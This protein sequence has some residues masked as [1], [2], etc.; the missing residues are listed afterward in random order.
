VNQVGGN[1]GLVFDGSSILLDPSGAVVARAACFAEDLVVV[2]LADTKEA[3]PAP[4]DDVAEIWQAL[5]L[6][7]RDYIRKCG[8]SKALI[9]LSGGI[10]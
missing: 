10:D 2:D 5:V 3:A 6:G 9:G 7:T 8:F 1:D 4:C